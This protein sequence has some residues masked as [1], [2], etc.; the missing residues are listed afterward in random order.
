MGFE[1]FR[2]FSFGGVRAQ[3]FRVCGGSIVLRFEGE[4]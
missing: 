2:V 4:E 3:G 1:D